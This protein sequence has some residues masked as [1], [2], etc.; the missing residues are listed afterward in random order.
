[1]ELTATTTQ[2]REVQSVNLGL[3]NNKKTLQSEI[4]MLKQEGQRLNDKNTPISS[5]LASTAVSLDTL[6]K[7]LLM[8]LSK[9]KLL[10][11]THLLKPSKEVSDE[12]E[13]VPLAPAIAVRD[14][15]L[16]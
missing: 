2:L 16:A 11:L 10:G 5:Q 6:T 3:E 13:G 14:A 12:E 8:Q 4:D 1:M 15:A 9:Q 7:E